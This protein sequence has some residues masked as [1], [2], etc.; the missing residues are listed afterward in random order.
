MAENAVLFEI[1]TEK[2]ATSPGP[3]ES[4]VISQLEA[5]RKEG[6]LSL[7]HS[8]LEALAIAAARDVD[9]STGKGAPSGR[10]QLLRTMNEILANLPVA[11]PVAETEFLEKTLQAVT[12]PDWEGENVHE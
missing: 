11:P 3:V 4:G 8:G 5:L 7:E 6:Y 9:L 10:A 1:P 12:A 2:T